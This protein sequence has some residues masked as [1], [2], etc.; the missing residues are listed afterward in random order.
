MIETPEGAITQ[1]IP[2]DYSSFI[3]LIAPLLRPGKANMDQ[4]LLGLQN[5]PGVIR[6][7]KEKVETLMG[8]SFSDMGAV[9]EMLNTL[10]KPDTG[11]TN[12]R[13]Q[14]LLIKAASASTRSG[15]R[16]GAGVSGGLTERFGQFS[17][18][19]AQN[20]AALEMAGGTMSP[21]QIVGLRGRI[22][23]EEQE[24]QFGIDRSKLMEQ[25]GAGLF[26]GAG[27]LRGALPS[28]GGTGFLERISPDVMLLE[29]IALLAQEGRPGSIGAFSETLLEFENTVAAGTV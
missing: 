2:G 27:D 14:S 18:L 8:Q 23:S 29:K 21:S 24:K 7:L 25:A 13:F 11:S 10:P 3:K 17:I 26:K 16:F 4:L 22:L 1:T 15:A 12:E 6:F 5:N 9:D 19:Q 28:D 20:Q